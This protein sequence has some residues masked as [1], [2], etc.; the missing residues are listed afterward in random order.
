MT[1]VVMADGIDGDG[2]VINNGSLESGH[3]ISGPSSITLFSAA[4]LTVQIF[5]NDR[6]LSFSKF[7]LGDNIF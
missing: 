5:L 7:F 1:L 2:G 4:Q 6:H 3:L